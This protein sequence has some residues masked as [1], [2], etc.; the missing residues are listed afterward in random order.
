MRVEAPHCPQATEIQR[1]NR[2]K[3]SWLR[4][5]K[6]KTKHGSPSGA[7]WQ[8]RALPGMSVLHHSGGGCVLSDGRFAIF[9]GADDS[10]AALSSCE[11]LAVDADGA[12]W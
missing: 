3:V 12:R 1:I 2:N 5:N 7:S 9:G 11:V 4:N 10:D 8:W 6:L